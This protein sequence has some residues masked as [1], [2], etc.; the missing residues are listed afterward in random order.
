MIAHRDTNKLTTHAKG[1]RTIADDDL[2]PPAAD[3]DASSCHPFL[4][5]LFL[6]SPIDFLFF[7][8]NR[9]FAQL[10]IESPEVSQLARV[11]SFT[12][13]AKNW[14]K[15]LFATAS[16]TKYCI[17]HTV[18]L[19]ISCLFFLLSLSRQYRPFVSIHDGSLPAGASRRRASAFWAVCTRRVAT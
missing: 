4:L 3:D 17:K 19:N 1:G 2:S 5:P 8:E 15:K 7:S 14:R 9:L 12:R 18:L 10:H 13:R 6:S 16:Y 11:T